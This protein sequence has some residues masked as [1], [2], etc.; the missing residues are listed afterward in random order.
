[1]PSVIHSHHGVT[2]RAARMLAVLMAAGLG[3]TIVNAYPER[4]IRIVVPFPPGGGTDVVT[5]TLTEPLS[6]DLGQPVIVENRAGAATIIGTEVVAKSAPDGYTLLMATFSH[7]VNPSLNPKLPYSTF[8]AF[9]PVA[10]VGRSPNLV[11]VHPSQPYQTM[12]AFTAFARAHPGRINYGSFGNG[13]SAHL[14][15]ELYKSIAKVELTHIPYKGSAP[16]LTDLMGGQIQV[17][18]TTLASVAPLV[19]AGKLRALAVTSAQRSPNYPNLPTVAETGVPSYFAEAWYGVYAPAGT[20]R[21]IIMRLNAAIRRAVTADA[22]KRRL[23]D[24]GMAAVAG[25]PEALDEFVRA[26]ET[27]WRRVIA[28]ARIKAD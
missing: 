21:E 28:D 22:F 19:Q 9:A 15:G 17:M 4:A 7:A 8:Q 5:R 24:E 25:T 26:E 20:P 13:T 16:A 27:R 10:L 3:T 1:M 18:F 11:V 14:A 23:E 2:R 6:R 12:Q